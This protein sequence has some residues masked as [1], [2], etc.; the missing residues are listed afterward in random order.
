MLVLSRKKDET[1]VI[2]GNIEIE[3]LKVKGNTVR[4]GIKAPR[5]IKVLRGELAPYGKI[6]KEIVEFDLD[7]NSGTIAPAT[8]QAVIPAV[9]Q[10]S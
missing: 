9:A 1:I 4:L 5:N 2:D 3:V 6:G 8:D 10:A 7:L